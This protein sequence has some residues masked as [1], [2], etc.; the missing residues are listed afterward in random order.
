LFVWPGF[1]RTTMMFDRDPRLAGETKWNYT[2]LVHL[3]FEGITSFSTRPLR[4]ATGAGLITSMAAIAM[5]AVV[6]T[7]TMIWGDPV[8]GYPS[9]IM[10]VLL[11]GGIQLLSIGLMGEYVG[12][13]FIEAKQR[14]LFVVMDNNVR[15]AVKMNKEVEA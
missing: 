8:A 7:K 14:P 13:L 5:A 9:T 15:E 4:L 12:R 10:V 3:A 2:K 6:F 1:R 11:L